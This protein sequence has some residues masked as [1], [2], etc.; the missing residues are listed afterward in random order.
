LR[1]LKHRGAI[2]KSQ[3]KYRLSGRTLNV[4]DLVGDPHQEMLNSFLGIFHPGDRHESFA[5]NALLP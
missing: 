1:F 4:P 2:V 3:D 5:E